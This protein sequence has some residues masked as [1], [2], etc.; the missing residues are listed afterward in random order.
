MKKI[1]LNLR[2]QP[3]EVRR[4]VLHIITFVMAIIMIIL[5]V[6]SLNKNLSSTSVQT[7]MKK[8]IQQFSILKDNIVGDNKN[9]G[10]TKSPLTQ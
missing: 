3:E 8:D 4:H 1:I 5:W 10:D 2:E 6:Y 7:K 9:T